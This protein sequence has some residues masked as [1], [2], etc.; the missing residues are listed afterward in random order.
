MPSITCRVKITPRE[1]YD[2]LFKGDA[3]FF[4]NLAGHAQ[5]LKIVGRVGFVP[6]HAAR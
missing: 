2:G 5:T 1:G 6:K 4:G 3:R